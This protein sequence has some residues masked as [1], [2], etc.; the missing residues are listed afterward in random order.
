MR[1]LP[2]GRQDSLVQCLVHFIRMWYREPGQSLLSMIIMTCYYCKRV[3]KRM[4]CTKLQ[5]T[6]I[7]S[8]PLNYFRLENYN[9]FNKDIYTSLCVCFA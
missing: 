8:E 3:D 5:I 7:Y 6:L 2:Y 9:L 1:H 4:Q